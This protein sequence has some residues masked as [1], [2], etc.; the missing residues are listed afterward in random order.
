VHVSEAGNAPL[1]IDSGLVGCEERL[2]WFLEHGANPMTRDRIGV[3]DL[4]S[5]AAWRGKLRILRLLA[6]H[7]ADFRRTKALNAAAECW[8]RDER[9]EVLEYL[10]DEAEVPINQR[11][12]E[13]EPGT[14]ERWKTTGPGLGTALHSAV[15]SSSKFSVDAVEFLLSR[16]ADRDILNTKGL[17]AAD[18]AREKGYQEKLALLEREAVGTS[19]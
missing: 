10:L 9:I 12:F 4:A 5:V 8:R 16:G 14:F 11:E 3:W 1:I 19:T 17:K 7:G 2:R 6:E 13:H 15:A 18:I